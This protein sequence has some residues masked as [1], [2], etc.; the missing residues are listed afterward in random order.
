MTRVTKPSSKMVAPKLSASPHVEKVSAVISDCP[1]T[2]S[3][4]ARLNADE[5][6]ST[7]IIFALS[8]FPVIMMT[9]VAVDYSRMVTVKARM[10][11]ALDAA[12]LSGARAAQTNSSNLQSAAESAASNYFNAVTM[13]FVTSKSLSPMV[14]NASKTTFTWTATSWV[15]TPFAAV[16]QMISPRAADASAPSACV[17]SWWTCQKVVTTTSTTVAVGGSNIGYSIET[18]FMLDIT[19]SMAGQKLTDLKSAAKDAVDILIWSDQTKQ[20]SRIAITPFS[21]EV[22][23]PTSSAYQLATGLAPP[24]SSTTKSYNGYTFGRYAGQYCVAERTGTNKYTDVAPGSGNYVLPAWLYTNWGNTCTSGSAAQPLTTNKT[25]LNS[26]IDSLSA[27]GGTAGQ[28]GTAWAWY[29]LS[30]NWNS[31]WPAAN[32]AAAYDAAY[33]VNTKVG[34]PTLQ[35]LKKIAILM[36]DGD[37]NTEYTSGGTMTDFGGSAANDS[38]GNQATALCTAMKTKGVEVYTVAFGSG[39]SSSAQTLLTNCATDTSHFYNASTGD[40]LRAAFRDIALKI[41]Q[42]RVSG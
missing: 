8:I 35:K 40:A 24:A 32:A 2:P 11:T 3:V 22:R 7:A 14:T 13:P 17:R 39:L 25:V 15:P 20:T 31:L 21:Q 9:G 42:I 36:T 4:F 30:P 34:D 37:Y 5:R 12:A 41:A 38:A 18:S 26:L 1:R 29:M 19:G 33:N 6:G 27:S 10:Q 28:I 16:G 23:L